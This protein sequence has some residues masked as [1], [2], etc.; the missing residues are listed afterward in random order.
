MAIQSIS[1]V[2]AAEL[3]AKGARLIDIRSPDEFRRA[4]AKGAENRPLDGLGQIESSQPIIFMCK[5]G[6]RTNSN[7]SQL[8][9]CSAGDTYIVEGGLD[10]WGA[11][12]LPVQEDTSQP[13]EMMRQVQIAAGA[14]ILLGV[15]LGSLTSPVWYGLSAFVG[16]GLFFAGATGW[17]GMANLLALMPWNRSAAI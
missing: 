17:C 16:A 2:E 1:P 13:L 15:L 4:K 3:A 7:S 11:A 5:S 14:L 9:G 8:D 12:G 10:A 6:M